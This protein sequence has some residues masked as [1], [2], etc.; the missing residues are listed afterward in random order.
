[1]AAIDRCP[2]CDV[3]LDDI[4]TAVRCWKCGW[5]VRDVD[6]CRGYHDRSDAIAEREDW[7][8]RRR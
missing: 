1:M 2:T 7:M 6:D 8:A 4:G 5:E 3:D